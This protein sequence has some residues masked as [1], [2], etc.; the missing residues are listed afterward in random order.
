MHVK[1]TNMALKVSVTERTRQEST[2]VGKPGDSASGDTRS[3][4]VSGTRKG[5]YLCAEHRLPRTGVR[6]KG[7]MSREG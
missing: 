5:V 2:G 4:A 6:A 3:S 7:Q 1:P